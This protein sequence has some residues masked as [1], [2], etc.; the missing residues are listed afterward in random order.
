MVNI[1]MV[2][3]S[4]AT[5]WNLFRANRRYGGVSFGAIARP[6]MVGRRCRSVLATGGW[7]ARSQHWAEPYSISLQIGDLRVQGGSGLAPR[8]YRQGPAWGRR[9]EIRHNLWMNSHK[10]CRFLARRADGGGRHARD[11]RHTGG[12]TRHFSGLCTYALPNA[13]WALNVASTPRSVGSGAVGYAGTAH[14]NLRRA[15]SFTPEG[16]E[17]R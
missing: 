12:V 2:P 7:S 9:G 4:S 5:A 1:S 6:I 3:A 8:S 16:R 14:L 11:K 13:G 10:L 15:G 17:D